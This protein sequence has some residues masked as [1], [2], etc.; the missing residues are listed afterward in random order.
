MLGIGVL[1]RR[2]ALALRG[3]ETMGVRLAHAGRVALEIARRIEGLPSRRARAAP[4]PARAAG[5]ETFRR[6][7]KGPSGVFSVVLRPETAPR[8]EARLSAYAPL[9]HRR[10]L[11]SGTRSLIAP[12]SVQ[13]IVTRTLD[14]RRCCP[15]VWKSFFI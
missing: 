7:F 12:M 5:H 1:A 3:I 2:A 14:R 9:R 15:R 10:L 8:L 13:A 11:G 6:D 4:G